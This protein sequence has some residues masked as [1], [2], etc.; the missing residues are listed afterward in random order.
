MQMENMSIVQ[1]FK[2]HKCW[3][4]PRR[5]NGLAMRVTYRKVSKAWDELH[6]YFLLCSKVF[7]LNS[8]SWVRL[9]Y[10]L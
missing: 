9:S 7:L 6:N 8:P 5:L 4:P 3:V 2:K 10:L 1:D